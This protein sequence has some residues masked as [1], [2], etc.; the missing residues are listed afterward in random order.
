[1]KNFNYN[2]E[3]MVEKLYYG[4]L[5]ERI[6]IRYI[7]DAYSN[8]IFRTTAFNNIQN[9]NENLSTSKCKIYF[10]TALDNLDILIFFE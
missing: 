8:N 6:L 2:E 9:S 3:V 5:K 10:Q 1:M 7:F 4:K